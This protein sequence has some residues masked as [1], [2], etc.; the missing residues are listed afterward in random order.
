MELIIR[1]IE[2][3]MAVNKTRV[4]YLLCIRN[5]EGDEIEIDDEAHSRVQS[6]AEIRARADVLRAATGW[7]IDDRGR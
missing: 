2:T 6:H 1:K 5:E 3:L 4:T 7:T